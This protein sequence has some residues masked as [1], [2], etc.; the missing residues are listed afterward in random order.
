MKIKTLMIITAVIAVVFGFAFVFIPE[1][2]LLLYGNPV[3]AGM[4][5]I[6][7]LFGA[8][9]ITF[10]VLTWSARNSP[11]NEA[12]KAIVLSLFIGYVI[13]FIVVLMGQLSCVVN[14]LGW[15]TVAIYFLL[16]L[17]YGYFHFAKS[18]S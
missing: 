2:F 17:G 4:K 9:L 1:Q 8:A 13:G 10:A 3:T 15:S 11:D 16:S 18:S 5:Y 6:G 14:V 12:R 7:Q